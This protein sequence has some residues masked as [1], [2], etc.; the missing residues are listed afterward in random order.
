MSSSRAWIQ[1]PRYRCHKEV[2]A[3]KIARISP[4]SQEDTLDGSAVISPEGGY[5]PFWVSAEYMRKHNPQIGG[6]YVV[7]RDGYTSWSPASEF[8]D[9]YTRIE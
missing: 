5:N 7:Y 1:M 9:G 6:Y 2:W 3:L 4:C 8:E